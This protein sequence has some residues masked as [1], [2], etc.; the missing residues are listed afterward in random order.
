MEGSCVPRSETPEQVR[1][2][3]ID[4]MF[5]GYS[6][7]YDDSKYPEDDPCP[8]S[9]Q[10]G[11]LK[12]CN[13]KK[14]CVTSDADGYLVKVV[15]DSDFVSSVSYSNTVDSWAF[16]NHTCGD[17]FLPPP[18]NPCA[19]IKT[20]YP[21]LKCENHYDI[22]DKEGTVEVYNYNADNSPIVLRL[23][24]KGTS[25]YAISRC[26]IPNKAGNCY[27]QSTMEGCQ[28]TY[29]TVSR[30]N[31]SFYA[32][33]PPLEYPDDTYPRAYD[34]PEGIQGECV[35]YCDD[36]F[37]CFVV[38][39]NG[40]YVARRRHGEHRY[41]I[42]Y[43]DDSFDPSIFATTKCDNVTKVDAPVNPCRSQSSSSSSAAQSSS[44]AAE[45]SA[46]MSASSILVTISVVL[47]SIFVIN[48]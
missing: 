46:A 31:E 18:I 39:E 26:D 41:R 13:D 7:E 15:K 45:S 43:Y 24:E 1:K 29:E 2:Q 19:S 14:L 37:V 36:D 17:F 48:L 33:V 12:Y 9:T 28:D 20:L 3:F 8:D 38:D 35:I 22:V 42:V 32:Y 10:K 4:D 5:A 21:A 16:A 30:V 40:R 6:V 47:A 11:C 44:S 25:D 27:E 34:C 23:G